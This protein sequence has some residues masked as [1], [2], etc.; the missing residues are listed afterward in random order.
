[1]QFFCIAIPDNK[2]VLTLATTSTIQWVLPVH[3]DTPRAVMIKM[4]LPTGDLLPLRGVYIC[5]CTA[6]R[7]HLL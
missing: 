7:L 5:G 6:V 1:M 3:L 4:V 2:Q